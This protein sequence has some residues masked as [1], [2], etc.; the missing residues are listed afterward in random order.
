[1]AWEATISNPAPDLIIRNS[2]P[3]PVLIDTSYTD[4]SISVS[5]FSTKHS[6]VEELDQR[7]SQRGACTH[8]ETDR[9]RTYPDGQVVIDTF[10]ADYRPAEGVD[11]AGNRIPRPG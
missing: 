11:C 1:M 3:Y 4:T 8:V 5:M 6:A 10:V 9:Q 2:T 7:V